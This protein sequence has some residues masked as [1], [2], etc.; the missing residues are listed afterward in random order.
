VSDLPFPF[1]SVAL[2]MADV[3]I[4][5]AQPPPAAPNSALAALLGGSRLSG[6]SSSSSSAKAALPKHFFVGNT[7]E[8][9]R[10]KGNNVSPGR[11]LLCQ[12]LPCSELTRRWRS[13]GPVSRSTQW[14]RWKFYVS[15]DETRLTSCAD[16]I[17]RLDIELARGYSSQG[18]IRF[19]TTPD[20]D[21][22]MTFDRLGY[23]ETEFGL[24]I[25]FVDDDR[26]KPVTMR[27]ATVFAKSI[28]AQVVMV[29]EPSKAAAPAVD[30]NTAASASAAPAAASS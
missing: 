6:A 11:S 10:D 26:R 23:G 5:A 25:V 4:A 20:A 30:A 18:P 24:T 2:V 15:R 8:D 27:Y 12:S 1:L 29:P 16:F 22:Q 7:A 19:S 28:Q 9:A 21:G 3:K 13:S 17:A 14:Y